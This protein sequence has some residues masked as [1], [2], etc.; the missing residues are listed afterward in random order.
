ML[1]LAP[2]KLNLTLDIVG[3]RPD[4]Y[5][6][7]KMVM[8]T[9]NLF[10]HI[11]LERSEGFRFTC[12]AGISA[13]PPDDRN[14]AVRAAKAFCVRAGIPMEGLSIS[15]EKA[16]PSGA[17]MGGGS[18]DAAGVLFG[19]NKL[20]GIGLTLSELCEIGETVGADVP[21]CLTG[22]TALVEGIGE[23]ITPLSPFPDCWFVTAKPDF[24]I[25]TKEAFDWFDRGEPVRHPDAEGMCAAIRR[26]DLSGAA[27]FL[28]NAFT[29]I[30]QA[31]ENGAALTNLCRLMRED[32]AIGAEMTGS[33][34]AVF[35]VFTTPAQA[36]NC[37]NKLG[38]QGLWARIC[39][40]ISCGPKILETEM[41]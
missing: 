27:H 5:H 24:S 2:A 18:A 9:V 10:D 22:G 6:L 11:E 38:N 17:G 25:N 1:I 8:Q 41:E 35:G 26:G 23:R 30:A 21:F 19:L 32:G 39:N 28:G 31:A 29:P 14:L 20:F 3:R 33:G 37:R 16:I 15:L 12:S 36:D 40:P 7:M 34:S 4:G 13:A